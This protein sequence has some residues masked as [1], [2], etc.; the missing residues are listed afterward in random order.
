VAHVRI[1]QHVQA[2]PFLPVLPGILA[3]LASRRPQEDREAARAALRA[4]ILA[5]I[6]RAPGASPTRIV[7]DLGIGWSTLYHHVKALEAQGVV[8]SASAGR[9]TFLY[10]AGMASDPRLSV[11]RSV[12]F[13]GRARLVGEE[14]ARAPGHD[15]SSLAAALD[16]SPRVVYH[17]VRRLVEAGLLR[18]S[19]ARRYR[20]LAATEHLL[21]L[22]RQE[23]GRSG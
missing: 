14:A 11:Q 5:A 22:L 13:G 4:R 12:L 16:I 10:P 17:H 7:E 2:A 20:D 3:S 15:V 21:A 1:E 9:H 19:M 8:R 6:E 18:S 23:G